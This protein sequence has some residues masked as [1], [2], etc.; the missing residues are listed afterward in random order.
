MYSNI[1]VLQIWLAQKMRNYIRIWNL[2]N[3]ISYGQNAI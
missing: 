3:E 1:I 2:I